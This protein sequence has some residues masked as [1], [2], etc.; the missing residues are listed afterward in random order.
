MCPDTLGCGRVFAQAPDPLWHKRWFPYALLNPPARMGVHAWKQ[1]PLSEG[2]CLRM[3]T[4]WGVRVFSLTQNPHLV[5][6]VFHACAPPP[7][8]QEVDH[9]CTPPPSAQEGVHA[10][11]QQPLQEGG[12]SRMHHASLGKGPTPLWHGRVL[13]Y[14][15][16]PLSA[17]GCS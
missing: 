13:T 14:T 3:C 10:C 16:H 2:G 9:T 8:A 1:I 11:A 12:C 4:A 15:P 17:G 5:R 6:E 7:L